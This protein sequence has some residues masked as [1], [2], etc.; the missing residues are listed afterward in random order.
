MRKLLAVTTVLAVVALLYGCGGSSTNE[1]PPGYSHGYNV[2]A[3]W[4]H[5]GNSAPYANTLAF[6]PYSS[7]D[8]ATQ[9]ADFVVY[10]NGVSLKLGPRV[11]LIKS[12]LLYSPDGRRPKEQRFFPWNGKRL[13]PMTKTIRTYGGKKQQFYLR[14]VQVYAYDPRYGED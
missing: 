8:H 2:D 6:P 9:S 11:E 13:A 14:R 1:K 10:P 5:E 12:K 4:I 7:I 3:Y